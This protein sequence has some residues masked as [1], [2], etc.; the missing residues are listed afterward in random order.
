MVPEQAATQYSFPAAIGSGQSDRV[1]RHC[2]IL[3][4]SASIG[5]L[6]EVIDVVARGDANV[7]I[8]GESGTGKELVA[9]EIHACSARRAH[10]FV[11]VNCAALP[12]SLMESELFGHVRGAFT[13]AKQS[14][15]GL[16][17]Q[18]GCGTVFL[19][20]I[21]EMPLDVQAKLLRV[22]ED[23]SVRP[24]GSEAEVPVRARLLAATNR[25]LEADVDTGRF[26]DDLYYR[27]N[28][29]DLCVPPLRARG[30][31]VLLLARHFLRRH[32][33]AAERFVTDFAPD[34]VRCLLDHSWPGNVRELDNCVLRAVT[35][36]RGSE[37]RR[38]DL[39][40]RIQN[41]CGPFEVVASESPED[42]IPLAELERRYVRRVL[43]AT[44][45]NKTAAARI[46]GVDRRTLYRLC[47]RLDV[48]IGVRN[49]ST[50]R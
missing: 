22:V 46:L 17:V 11:A 36:A 16:F 31:D 14:H 13:D 3:G 45:G 27:I 42:L 33:R 28:V 26:R 7:L 6:R 30:T 15:E 5:L 50:G 34:A 43:L 9:R 19:D 48:R 29:V 49:E 1:G 18:A 10:P 37:I 32:A 4:E 39:P 35:L 25:D 38:E 8:A 44:G 40:P 21:G 47:D 41:T 12:A 23:R 20:E 2:A 24:I